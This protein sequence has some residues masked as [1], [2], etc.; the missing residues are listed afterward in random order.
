MLRSNVFRS[1]DFRPR[2]GPEAVVEE[3]LG[4]VGIANV[5][6]VTYRQLMT[7][8][9]AAAGE[10]SASVLGF[11]ARTEAMLLGALTIIRLKCTL[12]HL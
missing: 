7:T 3:A 4:G 6:F 2:D 5:S 11:H 10:H 12:R 1:N 9:S 8:A